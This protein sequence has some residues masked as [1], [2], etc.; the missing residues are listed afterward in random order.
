MRVTTQN[1]VRAINQLPRDV[2]YQYIN[3]RNLGRIVI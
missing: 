2:E 3:P 1:L